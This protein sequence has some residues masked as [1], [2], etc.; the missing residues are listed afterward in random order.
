[1]GMEVNNTFE[2]KFH[3]DLFMSIALAT[4]ADSWLLTLVGN[5]QVRH[6]FKM[7]VNQ[8][9][10]ANKALR[11]YVKETT[12]IDDMEDDSECFSKV[13]EMIAKANSVKEKNEM[14]RILRAYSEEGIKEVYSDSEEI[15]TKEWI[16]G[17]VMSMNK[18]MNRELIEN[19]FNRYDN[20]KKQESNEVLL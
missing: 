18:G 13:L 11:N 1:M 12:S 5:N 6:R 4:Q 8:C 2:S 14:Y 19:L 3:F 9:A 7:L 20:R 10:G 17:F 16:I 15:R